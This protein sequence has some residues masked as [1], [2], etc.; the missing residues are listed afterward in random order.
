[1][2]PFLE[3]LAREG[4]DEQEP[5]QRADAVLYIN[6]ATYYGG[7]KATIH[8]PDCRSPLCKLARQDVRQTSVTN[9]YRCDRRHYFKVDL[10]D[11]GPLTLR[12][13]PLD[14]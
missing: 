1:M 6:N 7:A 8:C 11:G 3:E 5:E 13:T 4:Y 2:N 9:V 14:P 10:D 12:I